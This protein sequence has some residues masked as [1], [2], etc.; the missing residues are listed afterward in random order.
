MLLSFKSDLSTEMQDR[1]RE[2][3]L[4]GHT[5]LEPLKQHWVSQASAQGWQR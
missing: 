5:H 3:Q 2:S 1:E 4:P